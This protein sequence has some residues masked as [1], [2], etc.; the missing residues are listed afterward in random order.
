V[1]HQTL[2]EAVEVGEEVHQ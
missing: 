2:Q 1:V